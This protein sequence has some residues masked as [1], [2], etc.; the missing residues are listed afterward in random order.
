MVQ[1]QPPLSA[2]MVIQYASL[3][4]WLEGRTVTAADVEACKGGL[5][6]IW[7]SALSDQSPVHAV[8]AQL[9]VW[10]EILGMPEDRREAIRPHLRESL[11]RRQSDAQA[12]EAPAHVSPAPDQGPL[13]PD[14]DHG[15][16]ATGAEIDQ[17]MRDA[18]MQGKVFL[19]LLRQ[20]AG[21][22]PKPP[23]F[24]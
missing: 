12:A 4:A 14:V 18:Q 15:P 19:D 6:H 3:Q 21:L 24:L 22:G 17:A 10:G 23:G 7:M 9:L 1:E 20:G 8:L 5:A 13:D 11:R 16:G 2:S